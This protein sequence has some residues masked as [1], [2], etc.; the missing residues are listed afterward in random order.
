M[1]GIVLGVEDTT[2]ENMGDRKEYGK[3]ACNTNI[4]IRS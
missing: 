3:N 4:T 1:L 2:D